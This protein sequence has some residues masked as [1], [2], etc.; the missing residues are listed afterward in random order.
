MRA[1][2]VLVDGRLVHK[3]TGE[4]L[5]SDDE[6]HHSVPYVVS[7]IPGYRSPIDGS[8][9]EGRAARRYDLEKNDCV[10]VDPKP[11]RALNNKRYAV[12]TGS[13][14]TGK[15]DPDAK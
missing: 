15:Y 12:A 4:R 6:Y 10:P 14:W 3:D 2:Y 8:W 7:D 5:N 13:E 1:T 11:K 9:I